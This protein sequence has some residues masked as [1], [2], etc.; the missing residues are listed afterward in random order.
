[1]TKLRNAAYHRLEAHETGHR[2]LI[3]VPD[4]KPNPRAIVGFAVYDYEDGTQMVEA[5][6]IDTDGVII[7]ASEIEGE[8]LDVLDPDEKTKRET[9]NRVLRKIGTGMFRLGQNL[10]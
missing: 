3:K 5:C 4:H 1:M 8:I 10:L 9:R 2:L 6:V 7:P